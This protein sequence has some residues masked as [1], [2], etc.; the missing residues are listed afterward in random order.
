MDEVTG[1]YGTLRLVKRLDPNAVVAS[2]PSMTTM[3]P[4]DGT[5]TVVS[6]FIIQR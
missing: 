4:L 2:F 6:G 3:S 5:Q 1:L